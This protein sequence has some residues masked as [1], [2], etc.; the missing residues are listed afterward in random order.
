MDA[1]RALD[2][3]PALRKRRRVVVSPPSP[4]EPSGGGS[5]VPSTS[6]N[7]E[8]PQLSGD[9]ANEAGASGDDFRTVGPRKRRAPPA[10]VYN[11]DYFAL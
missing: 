3:A 6:F 2:A 7:D 5:P 8:M 4:E 9:N 11:A 10:F 1:A